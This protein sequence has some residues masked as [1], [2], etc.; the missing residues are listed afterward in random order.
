MLFNRSDP[1]FRLSLAYII[2]GVIVT[3]AF[4]AF[5]VGQGIRAQRLPVKVGKETM[6]GK[7]GN[8]LTTIDA[9]GGKIFVAGEYW[10]AISDT[11][12]EKG[13]SV[14]ITAVQGLTL[15]VQSEVP[16]S[17][18]PLGEMTGEIS[19]PAPAAG[20]FRPPNARL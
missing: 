10:N 8:A 4:F 15:S 3:A 2:P 1:L 9:S 19:G 17:L 11:P 5:V 12:V 13:K 16:A 14:Q 7:T 20:T 6:L 18:D